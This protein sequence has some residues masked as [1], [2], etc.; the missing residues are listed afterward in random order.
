MHVGVPVVLVSVVGS[1]VGSDAV[2]VVV[3]VPLVSAVVVF[4]AD[5]A[6]VA[7]G[8]VGDEVG[9]VADVV[10]SV[11]GVSS[12]GHAH[13]VSMMRVSRV[14]G[15][16]DSLSGV[17]MRSK[18]GARNCSN[19]RGFLGRPTSAICCEPSRRGSGWR[20]CGRLT[21]WLPCS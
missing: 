5:V 14:R 17:A 9:S 6:V 21:V 20:P 13:S 10:E 8:S 15:T 18:D 2:S 19:T 16:V 11:A 3:P 12:D 1:V 4:V 7:E